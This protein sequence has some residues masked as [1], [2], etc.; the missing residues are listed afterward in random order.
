MITECRDLSTET[1][2]HFQRQE[3]RPS[4]EDGQQAHEKMFNTA[5]HQGNAKQNHKEI[6]PHT[7]QNDYP[8]R[9]QILNV[10]KDVEK[11]EPFIHCWWE[12]K[13]VQP[14]YGSFSKN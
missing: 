11:R 8:Q 7:Y 1:K 14:L 13:L 12:C 3:T 5:N 10:G 2:Q 6:S 4:N 9:T